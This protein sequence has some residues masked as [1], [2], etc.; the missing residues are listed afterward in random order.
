MRV[1][2]KRGLVADAGAGAGTTY[3]CDYIYVN[4]AQVGYAIVGGGWSPAAGCGVF[5]AH[6][7]SLASD[8]NAGLG[9]A[10]S[11]KPLAS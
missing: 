8:A 3:Y 6:L 1:V 4:N 2:N 5:C 10:L 7:G 9:A 11:C